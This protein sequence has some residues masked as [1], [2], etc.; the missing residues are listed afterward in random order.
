MKSLLILGHI[1]TNKKQAMNLIT[2]LYSRFDCTMES[3]VAIDVVENKLVDAGF[4][5]WTEVETAEIASF[6]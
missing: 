3:S 1:I 2:S 6:K 5:S 4:L